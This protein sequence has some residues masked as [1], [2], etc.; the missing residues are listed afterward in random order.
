MAPA[1][2]HSVQQNAARSSNW[3]LWLQGLALRSYSRSR[4]MPER[5]ALTPLSLAVAP[6]AMLPANAARLPYKQERQYAVGP[7]SVLDDGPIAGS[8]QTHD[9]FGKPRDSDW[10][11]AATSTQT[12]DGFGKPRDC[13]PD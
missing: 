5:K 1:P 10:D 2:V 11:H 9:G 12:F 7:D 13:D 8:T 4:A 3:N 6:S